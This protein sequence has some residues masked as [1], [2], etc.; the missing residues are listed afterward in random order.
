MKNL[1]LKLGAIAL[2]GLLGMAAH[3]ENAAQATGPA[4]TTPKQQARL[5]CKSEGKKGKEFKSCVKEALEQAA[6]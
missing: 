1:N 5:K 3:A 4:K 2:S 6:H